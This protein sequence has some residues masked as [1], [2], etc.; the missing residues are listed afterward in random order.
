MRLEQDWSSQKVTAIIGGTGAIALLPGAFLL[1]AEAQTPYPDVPAD[2]WAQPIIQQ[3]SQAEILTGY[4]DGTFRPEQP[5]DRDEYAA[6]IRQAFDTETIRAL[7]QA[8]AFADVPDNY[9][10]STAIEEAYEMGFMG[11]PDPNEFEP[12]T[13]ISRANAIVALVEGLALQEEAVPVAAVPAAAKTVQPVRQQG[14]TPNQLAFPLAGTAMMQ[15]FA[16]PTTAAPP[17][18]TA[19]P[20]VTAA[21]DDAPETELDLSEYYTDAAQ[22]PDYA[23]DQIALATQK[24]LVVNHP[25]PS[26]LNPNEP[27][28][29]GGAAALIYQ[30][31]VY[32]NKLEPLPETAELSQFVIGPESAPE[33]AD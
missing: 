18:P 28:S 32:E 23:L 26:V 6:V 22:I 11:T 21:N 30:A 10:A 5:I 29:R 1:V 17:P 14:K 2:Y 7:P 16:L 25:E 4:P 20:A 31:L 9:W 27:I 15:L 8:S 3:L 13:E 12:K 33:T 24:G 19:A